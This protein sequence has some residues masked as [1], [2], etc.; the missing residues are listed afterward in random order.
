MELQKNIKDLVQHKLLAFCEQRVPHHVRDQVK[1][2]IES[3]ENVFTLFEE[4]VRFNNPSQWTK[5]SIAQ[6]RYKSKAKE[7][8]LYCLDRNSRWHIYQYSKPT[9]NMDDLLKTLDED[10][11]GIFWG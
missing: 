11:T 4:S 7:W 1:L 2:S 6:F 9:K 10:S 5:S 3:R 8:V